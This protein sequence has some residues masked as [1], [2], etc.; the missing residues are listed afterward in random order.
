MQ[1]ECSETPFKFRHHYDRVA[2]HA[3]DK[4]RFPPNLY[5]NVE[6]GG[7]WDMYTKPHHY[8]RV[9][10]GL[11]QYIEDDTPLEETH[12]GHQYKLREDTYQSKGYKENQYKITKQL[13]QSV[14]ENGIQTRYER[15]TLETDKPP[16]TKQ[17]QH[18]ITVNIDR[19]GNYI[20]NN[21]A[22]NRLALAKLFEV[23]SIPVTIV[24]KHK[25]APN[26]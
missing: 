18:N 21:T 5:A 9:F 17:P 19:N 11:K 25:D 13:I 7:D 6:I 26:R 8:D 2:L 10:S 15:G 1:V 23:D 22:H 12:Y 14:K 3:P 4:A 24:V 16:Y 20:F